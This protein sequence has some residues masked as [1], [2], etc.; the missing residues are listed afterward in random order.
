MNIKQN[1]PKCNSPKSLEFNPGSRMFYCT[2][3]SVQISLEN[4]NDDKY[5]KIVRQKLIDVKYKDSKSTNTCSNCEHG[6]RIN[7]ETHCTNKQIVTDKSMDDN[8]PTTVRVS[9][10]GK[11]K[12]YK[13]AVGYRLSNEVLNNI[14]ITWWT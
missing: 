6:K 12:E 11:C 3:C 1:C 5:K 13:V 9:S 2:V 8:S 10:H 14:F 7:R 4:M